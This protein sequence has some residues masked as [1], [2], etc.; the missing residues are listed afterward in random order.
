MLLGLAAAGCGEVEAADLFEFSGL[1]AAAGA[2]KSEHKAQKQAG[3]KAVHAVTSRAIILIETPPR[4][5]IASH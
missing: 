4:L 5:P 2:A 1:Q 3:F